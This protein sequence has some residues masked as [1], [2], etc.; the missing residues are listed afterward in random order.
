MRPSWSPLFTFSSPFTL[1]FS[2]AGTVSFRLNILVPCTVPDIGSVNGMIVL[3]SLKDDSHLWMERLSSKYLGKCDLEEQTFIKLLLPDRAIMGGR[4]CCY[5]GCYSD[6]VSLWPS[7][8]QG[9]ITSGCQKAGLDS[10]LMFFPLPLGSCH[11]ASL[12]GCS[13]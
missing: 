11:C 13:L 6:K 12:S 8:E 3:G 10:R 1:S 9:H 5:Y 7:L 4:S 2:R